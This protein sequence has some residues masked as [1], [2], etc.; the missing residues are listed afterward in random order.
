MVTQIVGWVGVHS[1][2]QGV[3]SAS[4]PRTTQRSV[5]NKGI[6]TREYRSPRVQSRKQSTDSMTLGTR[7]SAALPPR[8]GWGVGGLVRTPS[9]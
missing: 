5:P 7:P 6:R 9:G 2:V 3:N 4:L 8:G 1:I